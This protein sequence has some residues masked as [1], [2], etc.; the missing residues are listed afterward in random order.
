MR[1][2]IQAGY[3]AASTLVDRFGTIEQTEYQRKHRDS[4]EDCSHTPHRPQTKL[5]P[6]Q[7][8]VAVAFRQTL[9]V[10]FDDQLAVVR[11]FLNHKSNL[12]VMGKCADCDPSLSSFLFGSG[13]GCHTASGADYFLIVGL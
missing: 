5:T 10:S 4:V 6:A 1:P 13:L 3:E 12:R 8:A 7:E 11:A 9:L 2:A